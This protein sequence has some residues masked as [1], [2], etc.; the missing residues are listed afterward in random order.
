[1]DEV[2]RYIFS[3]RLMG[4]AGESPWA[5]F[6][7]TTGRRCRD[8]WRGLI[9]GSSPGRWLGRD[10]QGP[11]WVAGAMDGQAPWAVAQVCP[12]TLE[13]LLADG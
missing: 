12:V 4:S 11:V 10:E 13:E 1:M 6:A 8:A 5:R 9:P 7:A 3:A 2:S